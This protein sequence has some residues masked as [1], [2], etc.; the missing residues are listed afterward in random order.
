MRKFGVKENKDGSFTLVTTINNEVQNVGRFESY[1]GA[2]RAG[3]KFVN[4]SARWVL[5][6][7]CVSRYTAD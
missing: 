7:E 3:F 1:E 5:D 4:D 6:S 2:Y